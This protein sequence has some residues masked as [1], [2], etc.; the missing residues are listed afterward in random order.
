MKAAHFNDKD[1]KA[2]VRILAEPWARLAI[3][4]EAS[5]ALFNNPFLWKGETLRS[6]E[7]VNRKNLR[8]YELRIIQ[9]LLR[10]MGAT[11]PRASREAILKPQMRKLS[12]PYSVRQTEERGW[13]F[14]GFAHADVKNEMARLQCALWDSVNTGESR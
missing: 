6:G 1:A 9:D 2:L 4:V 13:R 11:I 7:F 5:V 14:H 12:D 3:Q 10:G 8:A